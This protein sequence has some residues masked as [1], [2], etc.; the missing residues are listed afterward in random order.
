MFMITIFNPIH[1]SILCIFVSSLIIRYK[2]NNNNN[3]NKKVIEIVL[4]F[5][6]CQLYNYVINLGLIIYIDKYFHLDL[7]KY[8]TRNYWRSKVINWKGTG[9]M[10]LAVSVCL[11][12]TILLDS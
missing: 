11:D 3:Y 2:I 7:F 9:E 4:L 8:S 6:Y 12:E 10:D 1:L 5:W